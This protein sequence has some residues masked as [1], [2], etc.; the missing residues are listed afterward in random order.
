MGSM[1]KLNDFYIFT[2][3]AEMKGPR[4]SHSDPPE[5]E[6]MLFNGWQ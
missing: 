2:A 5:N 4:E 1:L 6:G 3:V